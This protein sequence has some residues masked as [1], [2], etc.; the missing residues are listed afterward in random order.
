MGNTGAVTTAEKKSRIR[1]QTGEQ[2]RAVVE[3]V[4][5]FS[6]RNRQLFDL[7][8]AATHA[9]DDHK[10][11][12]KTRSHYGAPQDIEARISDASNRQQSCL[13]RL[14]AAREGGL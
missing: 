12:V 7:L 14:Y 1:W 9:I 3:A 13:E 8:I 4:K 6:T 5:P 11:L 2:I 10:R